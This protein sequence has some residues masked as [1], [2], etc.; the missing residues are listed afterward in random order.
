[1]AFVVTS[2]PADLG[3]AP[4]AMTAPGYPTL[5]ASGGAAHALVS[6]R[7]FMGPSVDSE[8]DGQPNATATGDD[9]NLVYPG[10]PFPPGDENGV[11]FLTA[12]VPGKV[13]RISGH[14]IGR[15]R[16]GRL[17]RLQRQ[18]VMGSPTRAPVWRGQRH[19]GPRR[20]QP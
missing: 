14:G 10:D 20:Y 5:L 4:D 9:I 19:G 17:D 13:A 12:I 3:D 1:M 8:L 2:K 18:R 6:G 15:E 16:V 7:P 11:K